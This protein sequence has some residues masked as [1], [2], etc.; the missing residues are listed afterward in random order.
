MNRMTLSMGES[1]ITLHTNRLAH[2]STPS[3]KCLEIRQRK[4]NQCVC[5]GEIQSP[6]Q[7]Q[8]LQHRQIIS[9]GKYEKCVRLSSD[10]AIQYLD[11]FYFTL[12]QN[13]AARWSLSFSLVPFLT[14]TNVTMRTK[15]YY[16]YLINIMSARTAVSN[17][18]TLVCSAFVSAIGGKLMW[19]C[20]KIVLQIIWIRTH[21]T[22]PQWMICQWENRWMTWQCRM[23]EP[24]R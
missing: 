17:G 21:S 22:H 3:P 12:V 20:L 19:M 2:C 11:G 23:Y 7:Q 5:S 18:M 14:T 13:I 4:S 1:A 15:Y 24:I 8:Q 16:Y 6:Q 10:K 9:K